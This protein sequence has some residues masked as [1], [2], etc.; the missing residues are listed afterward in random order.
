MI[1]LIDAVEWLADEPR[2]SL[3]RPKAMLL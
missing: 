1:D 3:Y 2:T